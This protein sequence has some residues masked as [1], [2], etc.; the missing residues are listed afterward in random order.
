MSRRP[1]VVLAKVGLDGHDV[2]VLL[3]AKHLTEAGM[4]VV[5]LGKRNLPETIVATAVAEDADVVGVSSLSGGLG[6]FSVEVVR[7]LAEQGADIPVITGG[8]AE[9]DEI[10][11]A[12]DAGV[13]HHFGPG[14]PIQHVV[15]TFYGLTSRA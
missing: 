7:L 15:D 10:G 11:W 9:D 1:R 4:E 12:I 3:I 8:I 6:E 13:R 14:E 2:G 5:Y